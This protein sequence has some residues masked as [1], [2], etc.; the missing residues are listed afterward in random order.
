ME[1]VF[2]VLLFVGVLLIGGAVYVWIRDIEK[3]LDRMA[4]A[5]LNDF[6]YV[7]R[8]L[9]T[10]RTRLNDLEGRFIDDDEDCGCDDTEDAST[11]PTAT[12]NHGG[13]GPDPANI[14][15]DVQRRDGGAA[16][17]DVPDVLDDH[18]GQGGTSARVDEFIRERF[19]GYLDQIKPPRA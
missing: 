18:P 2:T 14:L 1:I 13:D 17:V 9:I 5:L 4:D 15:D 8:E 7:D 3:R 10:T 6:A 11:V 16:V 19:R 12:G